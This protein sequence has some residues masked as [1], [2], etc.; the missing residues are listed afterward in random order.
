MKDLS[1]V[2]FAV[3]QAAIGKGHPATLTNCSKLGYINTSPLYVDIM[4]NIHEAPQ[5]FSSSCKL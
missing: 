5:N 2:V 4:K 1:A 3:K